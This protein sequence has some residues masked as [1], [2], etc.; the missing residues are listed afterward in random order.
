MSAET[1]PDGIGLRGAAADGPLACVFSRAAA[2]NFAFLAAGCRDRWV[3]E[4]FQLRADVQNVKLAVKRRLLGTELCEGELLSFGAWTP[5][6]VCALAGGEPEAEPERVRRA[7]ASLAAEEPGAVDAVLDRQE[8]ELVLELVRPS[9]FLTRLFAAHA[10]VEN[11][12]AFAR[13]RAT[14]RGRAVLEQAFL[15]GGEIPVCALTELLGADRDTVVVRFRF[16]RYRQ[17]VEEGAGQEASRQAFRRMERAGREVLLSWLKLARYATFGYE[18]LVGY[19]MF[20][21]NEITN[22]RQLHAAKGAG[23]PE[24]ECRE[25]V[26]YVE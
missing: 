12:R 13:V 25:L 10:D 6:Q 14:G 20:R 16:S 15:P 21:E 4:T 26:A 7:V 9:S 8:Q 5:K 22:L 3:L 23:A 1:A 24:A 2:D 17:L 19:Y 11:L 18:P